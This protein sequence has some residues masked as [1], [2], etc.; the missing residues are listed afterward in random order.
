MA[1]AFGY[2]PEEMRDVGGQL[3]T[4]KGEIGDKVVAAKGAVDGLIGA[5]FTSAVA[6]GAYSAQFADLSTGLSQV[7][8]N[9]EPLGQFLQKYADAVENM[10]S[11]LGA[12]LG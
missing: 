5:G 8:D 2:S 10:D 3:I 12:Q 11:E 9:L 1:N 6:S 7:A 4:I